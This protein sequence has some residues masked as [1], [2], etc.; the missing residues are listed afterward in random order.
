MVTDPYRMERRLRDCKKVKL[1]ISGKPDLNIPLSTIAKFNGGTN[2]SSSPSLSLS[3]S[4]PIA[5]LAGGL[6][7]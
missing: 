1:A 4:S 3:L 6:Y 5:T 2:S 7:L